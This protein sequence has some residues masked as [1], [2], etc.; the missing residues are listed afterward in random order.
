MKRKTWKDMGGPKPNEKLTRYSRVWVRLF[1]V[2]SS[3]DKAEIEAAERWETRKPRR[4]SI[5]E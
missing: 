4:I 1:V 5:R 3:A 2:Q